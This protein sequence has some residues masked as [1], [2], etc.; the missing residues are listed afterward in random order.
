[1]DIALIT[2][3]K[4]EADN[5]PRLFE[6]MRAQSLQPSAW[7][8]VDDGSTDGSTELIREFTDEVEWASRVSTDDAEAYDIGEHYAR[9]LRTGFSFLG[10]TVGD[11]P[12]YYMILDGDMEITEGYL[13]AL[14]EFVT[15]NPAVAVASGPIYV[16]GETGELD[17]E[18]R[19]RTE[20]AGGATLIDG[21]L[22]RSIG[23]PPPTPCTDSVT[24]AKARL[25][26]FECRHVDDLGEKAIQARPSR[27]GA[28]G[29]RHLG[30][31]NYALG[32]HPLFAVAKA[33]AMTLHPPR[34]AGV[35][36][37][38]GYL[39][40]LVDGDSRIPDEQVRHYFAYQKPREL[41]GRVV[42]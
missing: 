28:S 33:A 27:G 34:R 21:P 40:A 4:D 13:S 36:Y 10:D 3:V 6:S 39:D 8:I 41:L 7:A 12:D 18:H 35:A 1:M 20:P 30:A 14:A 9:V 42:G 32:Y 26:G 38:R 5:L 23:G 15:S 24:K 37:A 19:M 22:Y 11:E 29:A 2:P 16:R 25:R 31:N 17:R